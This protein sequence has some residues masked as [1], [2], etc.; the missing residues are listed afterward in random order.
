MPQSIDRLPP[1]LLSAL[2]ERGHNDTAIRNMAS[3]K[4]VAEYAG[5]HLGDPGWGN[6]FFDL[7]VALTAGDGE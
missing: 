1:D 3:R 5:W 4:M 7:V 2:R 6:T